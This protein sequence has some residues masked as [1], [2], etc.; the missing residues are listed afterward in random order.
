MYI[1]KYNTVVFV[2]LLNVLNLIICSIIY[3]NIYIYVLHLAMYEMCT[4][5]L[6]IGHLELPNIGCQSGNVPIN[7]ESIQWRQMTVS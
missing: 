4:L 3:I 5:E 2:I 6:A 1:Y 7:L